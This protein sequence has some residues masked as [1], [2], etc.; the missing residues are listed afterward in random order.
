MKKR[1]VIPKKDLPAI[2]RIRSNN[3][4]RVNYVFREER[5]DIKKDKT[6][7]HISS[8]ASTISSKALEEKTPYEIWEMLEST[9]L[10]LGAAYF[11][12]N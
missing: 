8:L 11:L 10:D 6:A 4:G 5:Y 2:L 12:I 7:Y 9:R 3:G 1:K